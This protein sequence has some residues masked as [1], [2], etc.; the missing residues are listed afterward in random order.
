MARKITPPDGGQN[1][2]PEQSF[3]NTRVPSPEF[4][5]KEEVVVV[6]NN[7]R[8]TNRFKVLLMLLVVVLVVVGVW[9]GLLVAGGKGAASS[10]TAVYLASGDIYFGKL[11]WFPSPKLVDAWLLQ[12]SVDQQNQP[13]LGLVPFKNAF[14]KPQGDIYLNSKQIL[15]WAPVAADSQV[16]T[17]LANPQAVQQQMQQQQQQQQPPQ[18]APAPEKKK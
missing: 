3:R 11:Y 16:A 7:P 4:S 13:Q 14:W 10:Y 9:V 1:V 2:E 18:Q 8:M 6:A 15:F 17:A 5:I 12:R